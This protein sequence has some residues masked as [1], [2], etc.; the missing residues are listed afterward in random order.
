[1]EL[2]A[3]GKAAQA[4]DERA[5]RRAA[6]A[7]AQAQLTPEAIAAEEKRQRDN[8][9]LLT[10]GDVL[11]P[12]PPIPV[13]NG[14]AF[15]YLGFD[16]A[17]RGLSGLNDGT[18]SDLSAKL[19]EAVQPVLDGTEDED[20]GPQPVGIGQATIQWVLVGAEEGDGYELALQVQVDEQPPGGVVLEITQE[21]LARWSQGA[22]LQGNRTEHKKFAAG[23]IEKTIE[24]A[25]FETGNALIYALEELMLDAPTETQVGDSDD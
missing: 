22:G 2:D 20:E 15:E 8:A 11:E 19:A 23:I 1:M 16:A 17:E 25:A 6:A 4:V 24:L 18:D 3:R 7:E 14:G 21:M 9:D 10:G 12:S 5:R 13:D